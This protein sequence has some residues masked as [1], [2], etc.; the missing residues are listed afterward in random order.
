MANLKEKKKNTQYP[1]QRKN[2]EIMMSIDKF[3]ILNGHLHIKDKS[4]ESLDT[5]EKLY[6]SHSCLQ[7]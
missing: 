6:K 2:T 7:E 1:Y 3:P 4:M 5:N